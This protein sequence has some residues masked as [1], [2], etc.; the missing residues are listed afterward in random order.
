MIALLAREACSRIEAIGL[1]CWFTFQ[2][3]E[4][5]GMNLSTVPVT[6]L[7]LPFVSHCGSS[8]FACW[9]GAGLVNNVHL[10]G[11]DDLRKR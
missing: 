3:F 7:R 1:A 5:V 11:L 8:M 10:S 9:L 2:I 6:G 4:N